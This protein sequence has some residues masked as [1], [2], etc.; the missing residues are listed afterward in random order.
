MKERDEKIK[1][2]ENDVAVHKE[3]SQSTIDDL[4][5]RLTDLN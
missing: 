5:S 3:S 1:Q 2:L 4:N